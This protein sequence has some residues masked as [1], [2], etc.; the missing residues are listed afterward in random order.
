MRIPVLKLN[1]LTDEKLKEKLDAAKMETQ[2]LGNKQI[3]KLAGKVTRME[4]IIKS[5]MG[6]KKRK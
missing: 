6:R 3:L 1:V 2:E 4:L 5:L